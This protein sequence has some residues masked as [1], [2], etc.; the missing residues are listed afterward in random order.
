MD[1]L[2]ADLEDEKSSWEMQ[3]KRYTTEVK[4]LKTELHN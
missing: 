4:T 2:K 1:A 3:K